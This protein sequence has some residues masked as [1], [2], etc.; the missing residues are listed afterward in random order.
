MYG[1]IELDT[2]LYFYSRLGNSGARRGALWKMRRSGRI[3][4]FDFGDYRFDAE[5]TQTGR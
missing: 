1:I 5:E 3:L 2:K 4:S